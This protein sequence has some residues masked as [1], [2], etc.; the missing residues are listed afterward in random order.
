[1]FVKFA[2]LNRWLPV[3]VVTA[4]AGCNLLL[5]DTPARDDTFR[6]AAGYDRSPP[7]NGDSLPWGVSSRSRDV[8]RD[9]G[10]K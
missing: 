9:L 4:C 7:E 3:V 1:M 10:V 5:D 6:N 8:E 2:S